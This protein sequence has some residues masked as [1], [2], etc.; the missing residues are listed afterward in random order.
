MAKK[1]KAPD[2]KIEALRARSCLHSHP[3]SVTDP[4]FAASDF[5]DARDV[6]QVKYEMLRRVR[7][8]GQ[9]VSVSS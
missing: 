8:D 1:L 9:P 7:R 5:F 4:L 6:V 2:P 3:E